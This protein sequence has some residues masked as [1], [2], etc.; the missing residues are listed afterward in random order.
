MSVFEGS[1]P[2]IM[3]SSDIVFKL[4]F[5]FY[6]L[7]IS[8][9]LLFLD[10]PLL[11]WPLLCAP[12]NILDIL[13]QWKRKIL[14]STKNNL[15]W[16]KIYFLQRILAYYRKVY[17]AS[18]LEI[19]EGWE[20]PKKNQA[21]QDQY[22]IIMKRW[23]QFGIALPSRNRRSQGLICCSEGKENICSVWICLE[24]SYRQS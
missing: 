13:F 7:V 5:H 9:W 11:F 10:Q 19:K 6:I 14:A 8:I 1:K 12:S 23:R 17:V 22:I 21:T 4:Y 15:S 24:L 18:K 16:W 20:K 2:K 3:Q